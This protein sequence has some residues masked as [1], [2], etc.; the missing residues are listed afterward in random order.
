MVSAEPNATRSKK[1]NEIKPRDIKNFLPI[2]KT[3]ILAK[4]LTKLTKYISSS[5]IF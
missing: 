1:D 3:A 2:L 5:K 4:T